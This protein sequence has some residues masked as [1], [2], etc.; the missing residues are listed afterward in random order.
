MKLK[1]VLDYLQIS[2]T[3]FYN[4]VE[5]HLKSYNITPDGDYITRRFK[6]EDVDAFVEAQ[7]NTKEYNGGN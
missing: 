1:E 2:R 5:P 6:K 4:K 7:K 3:T